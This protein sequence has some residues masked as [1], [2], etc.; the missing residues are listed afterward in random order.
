MFFGARCMKSFLRGALASTGMAALLLLT[1]CS[2]EP[3]TDD[4]A[5]TRQTS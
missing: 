5:Y 1:A 3:D 2:R 4:V